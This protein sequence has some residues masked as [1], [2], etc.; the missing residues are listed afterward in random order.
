MSEMPAAQV[1]SVASFKCPR[2]TEADASSPAQTIVLG[3][4]L[5]GDIIRDRCQEQALLRASSPDWTLVRGPGVVELSR[6]GQTVVQATTSP[7]LKAFSA[8]VAHAELDQIAMSPM[9]HPYD[10]GL[11]VGGR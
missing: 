10:R 3:G 6:W 5:Q 2:D 11:F 9:P 1:W 8:P 4:A 7:A